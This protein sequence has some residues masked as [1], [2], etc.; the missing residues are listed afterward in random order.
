MYSQYFGFSEKPFDAKPDPRF[1]YKSLG[2]RKNIA[3]LMSGIY[4]RNGLISIIGEFGT[5][6]TTLLDAALLRLDENA[7]VTR[8]FNTNASFEQMLNVALA[9]LGLA[10]ADGLLYKQQ[11]LDRLKRFAAAQR[12]EGGNVV[13]FVD[14]AHNLHSSTIGDLRLLY[15]LESQGQRL[16]QVVLCGQPELETKL[17]QPELQPLAQGINLRL[18]IN[19]LN[20]EETYQYVKHC[21]SVANYQGEQL[22]SSSALQ[23]VWKY[24]GGI[25][26][27]INVVC[28]NALLIGYGRGKKTITAHVVKDAI[29]EL[30]WEPFSGTFETLPG[31]PIK[32]HAPQREKKSFRRL[33]ALAAGLGLFVF[34]VLFMWFFSGASGLSQQTEKAPA[35]PPGEQQA[36]V[37]DHTMTGAPAHVRESNTDHK[38]AGHMVI[39]LGAFR[40]KITADGLVKRLREKGY[41][42]YMEA[43]NVKNTEPYY[44]VR[45]RGYTTVV[46]ARKGRTQLAK[47][48]F[49]DSFIVRPDT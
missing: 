19:P 36:I 25:P 12:G 9:D 15:G 10:R 35:L 26:Q 24:S 11:G 5:G 41:E 44:R 37:S 20:Q 34:L 4:R 21:L 18:F 42:P 46:Q 1:L 29:G 43:K 27:K 7:K 3:S 22:F 48:G 30:C 23:A 13:F 38:Q 39:Q 28:D 17:C 6:K 8:I 49:R 40:N 31:I 16:V 45:L 47:K 32:K 2:Y 33:L 14:E